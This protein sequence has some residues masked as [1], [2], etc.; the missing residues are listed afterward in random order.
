MRKEDDVAANGIDDFINGGR[1]L[2]TDGAWHAAANTAGA[3]TAANS[4]FNSLD[5]V[6]KSGAGTVSGYI[7]S[8]GPTGIVGAVT[9][10]AQNVVNNANIRRNAEMVA[11]AHQHFGNNSGN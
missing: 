3:P 5:D 8:A 6:A 1:T 2:G 10:V 7:K 4:I 9:N 11:N